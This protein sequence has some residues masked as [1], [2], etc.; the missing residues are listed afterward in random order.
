MLIV[1]EVKK[2]H[3]VMA[4][5]SLVACL[6]S[7]VAQFVWNNQPCE[8]CLI[9][10]TLHLVTAITSVI[11]IKKWHKPFVKCIQVI[12]LA[13]SL[14]AGFY[15]LGVESKWWPA[16]E[17]CKTTLPG[18][19]EIDKQGI[20]AIVRQKPPACD[21][22]NLIIFGYSATL[23]NFLISAFIFWFASIAYA[24]HFQSDRSVVKP[25]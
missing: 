7:V 1:F 4:V 11:A 2:A 24:I 3:C 17:S 6:V 20:E 23:L 9:S 21:T 22:P 19:D 14:G 15:H 12:A 13:S 25:A 8:L 5:L 18:T 10:R 16:P